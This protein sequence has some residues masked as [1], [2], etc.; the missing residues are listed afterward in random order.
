[1]LLSMLLGR[2]RLAEEFG[3]ATSAREMNE[4]I[5]RVGF[6]EFRVLFVRVLNIPD[7]IHARF[8][9]RAALTLERGIRR[10]RRGG[11]GS[12]YEPPPLES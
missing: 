2:C 11:D 12:G 5:I 7:P 3:A 8:H 10:R 9:S 6:C 1:M 4:T